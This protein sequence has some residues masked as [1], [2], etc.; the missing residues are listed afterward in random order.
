ME[1]VQE[2]E[3]RL[4]NEEFKIWK[5]NCPWLYGTVVF[6]GRGTGGRLFF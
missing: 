6:F 4:I 3:E 2:V 1:E 5:K